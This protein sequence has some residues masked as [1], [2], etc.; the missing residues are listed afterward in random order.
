ML[1]IFSFIDHCFF[2]SAVREPCSTGLVF[3]YKCWLGAMIDL[4]NFVSFSSIED[5]NLEFDLA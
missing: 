2:L 5:N 3:V 1:S 4:L